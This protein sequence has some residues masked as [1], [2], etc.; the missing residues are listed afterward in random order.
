MTAPGG[1]KKLRSINEL[2]CFDGALDCAPANNRLKRR[3]EPE[4]IQVCAGIGSQHQNQ[5]HFLDAKRS[6]IRV[7]KML[8]HR[9]GNRDGNWECDERDIRNKI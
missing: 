6:T 9:A 5:D 1:T 4:R 8:C 2:G 7:R 3:I